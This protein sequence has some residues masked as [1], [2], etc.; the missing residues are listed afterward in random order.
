MAIF[1]ISEDGTTV[2]QPW[3]L[4]SNSQHQSLEEEELARASLEQDLVLLCG[5]HVVDDG[6]AV[7]GERR[8]DPRV[9]RRP[10]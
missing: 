10:G 5:R 2:F 7:E 4:P 1:A 8:E 3:R 9:R 6:A